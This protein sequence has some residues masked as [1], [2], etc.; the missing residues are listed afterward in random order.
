[1]HLLEDIFL[2]RSLFEKCSGKPLILDALVPLGNSDSIKNENYLI[3]KLDTPKYAPHSGELSYLSLLD[4]M[5][6]E[7]LQPTSPSS[8]SSTMPYF[9]E[10]LIPC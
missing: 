6:R 8:R 4:Y 7:H 9:R 5:W 10:D 1:M 2:A 3:Q